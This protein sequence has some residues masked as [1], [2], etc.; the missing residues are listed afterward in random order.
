MDILNIDFISPIG[1]YKFDNKENNYYLVHIGIDTIHKILLPNLDN[2]DSQVRAYAI[3]KAIKIT[4]HYAY[5]EQSLLIFEHNVKQNI[6]KLLFVSKFNPEKYDYFGTIEIIMKMPSRVLNELR[7][8]SFEDD[9]SFVKEQ[10]FNYETFDKSDNKCVLFLTKSKNPK[11]NYKIVNQTQIKLDKNY[12]FNRYHNT[13]MKEIEPINLSNLCQSNLENDYKK[14]VKHYS[15]D[16]NRY[17]PTNL[18]TFK[19][20]FLRQINQKFRPLTSQYYFN[21]LLNSPV[22]GRTTSFSVK[23]SPYPLNE[24][25]Q[26]PFELKTGSGILTRI[27]PGDYQRVHM[28]YQGFLTEIISL[29]SYTSLKFENTYFMPP[30]VEEREYISVLF[31]HRV[32]MSREYPELIKVQPRIKLIFYVVLLGKD[33]VLLNQKLINICKSNKVQIPYEKIWFERGE[34]IGSF[35]CSKLEEEKES[36]TFNNNVLFF[37]NRDIDFTNDVRYFSSEK[38][39]SYIKSK[40]IFGMLL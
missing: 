26:V 37:T 35:N 20:L 40:D 39:E 1:N 12:V 21:N 15:I 14:L 34:E 24:I 4:N 23:S 11:N 32:N 3:N 6:I 28:P 22:D 38:I 9:K 31:G 13:L 19:E 33:V 18:N 10:F 36:F 5:P 25:I 7:F 8:S 27:T 29:S 17:N 2:I 30:S 16:V